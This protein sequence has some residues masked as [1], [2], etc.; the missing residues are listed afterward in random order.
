MSEDS[1]ATNDPVSA[2]PAETWRMVAG[3]VDTAMVFGPAGA[4]EAWADGL[5]PQAASNSA[6][7]DR[8]SNAKDLILIFS[9]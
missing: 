7:R 4:P 3:A 8:N 9:S 6:A 5:E 2:K 1:S